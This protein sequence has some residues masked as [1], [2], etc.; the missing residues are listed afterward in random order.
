[1]SG[2][3]GML[4]ALALTSTG[5]E[6]LIARV[7]RGE[8]ALP[9]LALV[10]TWAVEAM[11]LA[12]PDDARS[13]GRRARWRGLVPRL[14]GRL[15]SDANVYVKDTLGDWA[16]TTADRRALAL[17]VEARFELGDLV[18]ADLELR[19]SRESIARSAAERLALEEVT[20][21]YFERVEVWLN[22]LRGADATA[23][24]RAAALDGLLRAQTGGRYALRSDRGE[25][26]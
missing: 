17:R 25:G 2:G 20:R 19:A 1:M 7:V 26:P 23:A 12:S 14:S 4:L 21:V 8:E 13:W 9:S 22:L 11:G 15:G 3:G 18:F 6:A 5:T 24:L 10:Q 16:P